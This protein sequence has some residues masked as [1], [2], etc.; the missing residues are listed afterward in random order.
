MQRNAVE[1][2]ELVPELVPRPVH[3]R[4]GGPLEPPKSVPGL[5]NRWCGRRD[6]NPQP[7]DP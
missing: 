5:V 7:S 2:D 3:R 1:F 6:S 4:V